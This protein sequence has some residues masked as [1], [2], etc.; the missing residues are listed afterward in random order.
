MSQEDIR[1]VVTFRLGRLIVE[2]WEVL[3]DW[4]ELLDTYEVEED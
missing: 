3:S 2:D 1:T 4:E